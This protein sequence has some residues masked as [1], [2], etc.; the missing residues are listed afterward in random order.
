MR[1]KKI[2]ILIT[3][4][5]KKNFLKKCLK[6]IF[7]QNYSNYEIILF[8]DASNDSSLDVIKKFKKFKK[9]KIIKNL[10]K[11]SKSSALN[12]INGIYQSFHKSKGSVICLMDADDYFM[13]DKLKIVN[14]FFYTKKKKILY[15]LAKTTQDYF[16]Y[17]KSHFYKRNWPKILPT[18]CISLTRNSFKKFLNLC[19]SEKYPYLEID[20]RI[21]IFYYYYFGE[22][23]LINR[24]ITSYNYD[25]NGITANINKYGRA[26]WLRRK[27]AFDFKKY[28]LNKKRKKVF[29]SLDFIITSLIVKL[30][31][32]LK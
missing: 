27:E 18:S 1:E 6:S 11:K 20:T 5:N 29:L 21:L 32:L 12:Q 15:N 2:S 17:K 22:Y 13:K 7:D 30:L 31:A 3:N 9:L 25:S 16:R 8:D 10:V 28:V 14:N 4:Y 23:N 26:W 19:K 24:K